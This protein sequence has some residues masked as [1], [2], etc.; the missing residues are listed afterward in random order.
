MLTCI[1]PEVVFSSGSPAVKVRGIAIALKW[2]CALIKQNGYPSPPE[3]VIRQ[4][5]NALGIGVT[6]NK[7]QYFNKYAN[8]QTISRGSEGVEVVSR[9]CVLVKYSA[10]MQESLAVFSEGMPSNF[11]IQF[12]RDLQGRN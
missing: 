6:S 4:D 3:E 11:N 1:N 12:Y 5:I 2:L 8:G 7:K 10:F 9:K